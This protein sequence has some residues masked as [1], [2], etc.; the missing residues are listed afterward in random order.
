MIPS[1]F[2][3]S[4]FRKDWVRVKNG[5]G[6][7][8]PPFSLVYVS[9]TTVSDGTIVHTVNRPLAASADFYRFFLVTG[10]FAIG[11]QSNHEG[12]ASNLDSPGL[13]SYD[14]SGTPAAGQ[15]WGPKHG[16]FT[17]SSNY[18]GFQTMGG[19]TTFNGINVTVA[20]QIGVHTVLGKIDDSSV[21]KGGTCTVSVHAG[22]GG[23]ETNTGMNI[24]GV[25]N[26]AIAMTNTSNKWCMVGW[27]ADTPY[28][29]WVE[30]S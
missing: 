10:P 22:A 3:A 20:R 12:I 24:T 2:R 26:R 19:N 11:Q 13:M 25:Y 15:V 4:F 9:A 14:S 18:F 5:S 29:L 27:N 8:I 16:Q 6:L 23:S 28:L 7:V 21:S 17:A 30:C 1:D